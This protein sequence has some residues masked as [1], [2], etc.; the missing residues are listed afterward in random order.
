MKDSMVVADIKLNCQLEPEQSFLSDLSFQLSEIYQ[1]PESSIMLTVSPKTSM[2]LGGTTEPAYHMSIA[3]LSSEI[4]PTKN[5]RSTALIQ[6]FMEECLGIA[7]RRGVIRFEPVAEEN[8]ASNGMTALQEIEGLEARSSEDN[9]VI[10]GIVRN[11]SK[12]GKKEFNPVFTGPLTPPDTD[13]GGSTDASDQLGGKRMKRRKSILAF[14]S[15]GQ[16]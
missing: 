14:F 3:A 10:R 1:R 8:L 9:G 13:A 4:A 16:N 11:R 6:D 15:R 12:K 5:K 7:S 2:V